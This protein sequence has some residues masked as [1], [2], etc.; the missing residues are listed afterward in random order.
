M[1]R[2]QFV[3]T[4]GVGV[5]AAGMSKASSS[6]TLNVSPQVAIT[7]DDIDM[8]NS[9][10]PKLSIDE[11]NLAILD[12][13][14]RHSGLKAALF[15]CGM[16]VDNENGRNHLRAWDK[17]GHII[18]NHSYSHFYYP[19]TE[20]DKFTQDVLRGEAIIKDS[21]NFQ[22]LFR[23]PYLKEGDTL[24]KRNKMRAFL[25]TH[26]YNMGYVTIDTSEW[27]IDSRLRDRLKKQPNA[28][29]SSYRNF[30]LE[31]MWDRAMFYDNLARKV[32]GRPVKH[33][34]LIHHNLVSALFL[35]D[36]LRMFDRKGWKL[37]D[38]KEAF[39]DPVFSAAPNITPAGESIIW[40]L[41]KESGKFDKLLRYPAED[42]K[43]E[44][45][46]MNKVGL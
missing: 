35:G 34:L 19:N 2:R 12:A 28:D 13:L 40:A 31:H 39:T 9:D 36:L 33:T 15:V 10:T 43:Y 45:P 4:L 8:N 5:V 11:R 17:D 41:A 22:K 1:N 29:L 6:H 26:G 30:Y 38:A 14:R 24:E 32:L 16:R 37:I 20:F 3:S 46:K 42:G 7:M 25:Q 44:T 21:S 18:A 27:V 23:F